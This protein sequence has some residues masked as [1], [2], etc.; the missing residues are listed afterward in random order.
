MSHKNF[1]FLFLLPFFLYSDSSHYFFSSDDPTHFHH[2]NILTGQLNCQFTDGKVDGIVSIPITRGYTSY[3]GYEK[4]RLGVDL[5]LKELRGGFLIQGGWNFFSH[6]NMLLYRSKNGVIK[7]YITEPN[8]GMLVYDQIEED[9]IDEIVLKPHP[10]S[11]PCYG[12]VSYRSQSQ[13]HRLKLNRS[14]GIATLY[15]ANGG[16]RTYFRVI[17]AIKDKE[18]VFE[19]V[20]YRLVEEILPSG[21]VIDYFYD[22]FT[23]LTRIEAKSWN[24]KILFSS[25]DFNIIQSK[26]FI[27][28][29]LMGSNGRTYSYKSDQY[30][31]RDYLSYFKTDITIEETMGYDLIDPKKGMFLTEV[32]EGF[33]LCYSV[34][35]AL[36]GEED[37]TEVYKVKNLYFSDP[38]KG[39]KTLFA[40][41]EY[42]E[43]KTIVQD[44]SSGSTQYL[45]EKDQILSIEKYDEN[46]QLL[47]IVKFIWEDGKL[48]GKVLLNSDRKGIISKTMRYDSVGNVVEE[49][50]YGDLKGIK[51][52]PFEVLKD[53]SFIDSDTYTKWFIYDENQLL[54]EE[55]EELGHRYR[56]RYLK[57]TD[58]ILEK[59]KY[60]NSKP[61]V[62]EKFFYDEHRLLIKETVEDLELQLYESIKTYKRDEKTGSIIKT[63]E[64]NSIFIENTYDKNQ[65]LIVE[66]VYDAPHQLLMKTEFFYDKK[67][68]ILKKKYSDGKQE[69]YAYD[70]FGNLVAKKEIGTPQKI[71][72]YDLH[73]HIIKT[74]TYDEKIT[75]ETIFDIRG[76]P[77]YQKNEQGAVTLRTYNCLN[78][79]IRSSSEFFGETQ[80][81][82][83]VQG[84]LE[85][86]LDPYGI[87]TRTSFTALG[88]PKSITYKNG[89]TIHHIYSLDGF[90]EKTVYEDESYSCKQMNPFCK[91]TKETWYD[92]EG[93]ELFQEV[94]DYHHFLLLHHQSKEGQKTNYQYDLHGKV[95][96]KTIDGLK[97]EYSYDSMGHLVKERYPSYTICSEYDFFGK[98]IHTFAIDSI[99]KI[100][101]EQEFTYDDDLLLIEAKTF[102]SVGVAIDRFSYD[103]YHRLIE[104]RD[105]CHAIRRIEYEK[106][107]G[108]WIKKNLDPIG[109]IEEEIFDQRGFSVSKR[110]INREGATVSKST[111]EYDL[112]G[113]QTKIICDIYDGKTFLRKK[114]IEHLYDLLGRKIGDVE[115][116]KKIKSYRY[117]RFG[118]LSS[119]CYP[120]GKEISYTFDAFKQLKRI[121]T[122]DGSVDYEITYENFQKP[123][124]F[125]SVKE[126]I[127]IERIYGEFS[128]C[129]LEKDVFDQELKYEYDDQNRLIKKIFPDQS[130]IVYAY[131][132]HLKSLKRFSPDLELRCEHQFLEYNLQGQLD[133]EHFYKHKTHTYS[134]YDLLNRKISSFNG[135]YYQNC[136]FNDLGQMESYQNSF[137]NLRAFAYDP[138]GQLVQDGEDHYAFDSLGHLKEGVISSQEELIANKDFQMRYD[139]DGN[140]VE[141]KGFNCTIEYQYDGMNRLIQID[142][143]NKK[144]NLFYD[145]LSR[146]VKIQEE[147]KIIY[148]L[149]D[150]QTDIGTRDE[151]LKLIELKIQDLEGRTLYIEKEEEIKT[152][153]VD[154]QGNIRG[155]FHLDETLDRYISMNFFGEKSNNEELLTWS[156]SSNRIIHGLIYFPERFYDPS[157]KRW[158]SKDPLGYV[159]GYN[160]YAYVLNA[161]TNRIDLFGL[162]STK[163]SLSDLKIP[164]SIELLADIGGV[165]GSIAIKGYIGECEVD[166]IIFSGRWQELSFS[167]DEKNEGVIYLENHLHELFPDEI[168][169]VGL[170]TAINGIQNSKED[171]SS[172]AQSIIQHISGEALFIGLYNP[173]EGLIGDISRSIKELRFKET[174]AVVKTRQFMEAIALHFGDNHPQLLWDHIIHSE[175]GALTRLALQTMHPE[176]K[177]KVRAQLNILAL[178]PALPIPSYMA[179][180]VKNIYS[181]SDFITGGIGR[182]FAW[183]SSYHIE[184]NNCISSWSERSFLF[185]DHAFL[186]RTYQSALEYKFKENEKQAVSF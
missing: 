13:N 56:Y 111:F 15:L 4:N 142:S 84:N 80:F 98:K 57:G 163:A 159:E 68:R 185:S 83:D 165:K 76:N 182:L 136:T 40:S 24:R 27:N 115:D 104:H 26:P 177:E 123:I 101:N 74:K 156:F 108:F 11:S 79:C 183:R 17:H 133:L 63:T 130:L 124:K 171:F 173:T 16:K 22:R 105:P 129:I 128:R 20:F 94:L 18:I 114:E 139:L 19:N 122:K 77:I 169:Q 179:R 127:G 6:T 75:S 25:L 170:I 52:G 168:G 70:Y 154:F 89:E 160:L 158:I 5:K 120:S 153:I 48:V 112:L 42:L 7:A 46:E 131:D 175:G 121:S 35:Y 157:T 21:H 141:K 92:T 58:L 149:Y 106:L 23:R 34:D 176:A 167:T 162:N 71:Y 3:G 91:V 90:I 103:S 96:E 144:T 65:R 29:Q 39:D 148:P 140:L 110:V 51:S 59:V 81:F 32:K 64:N 155:T 147:D 61:L 54:V 87:E 55:K 44:C 113:N 184:F 73:H 9:G 126:K 151:S 45:F 41:F 72:E 99:G 174:Q 82:Y 172:F 50:I 150:G 138:L 152:A 134:R 1:L 60:F 145:P 143:G 14:E 2:V 10:K 102:T 49:K 180:E 8:Q 31:G 109:Q 69:W 93:N 36:F 181:K 43:N 37:E 67:G 116:K 100:E 33:N 95:I 38:I 53:G 178:A 186:G 12:K 86:V 132:G 28:L 119:I 146:I 164:I 88:K 137:E 117:D 97:I 47:S 78:H 107:D 161:P 125:Y 85:K 118:N 166:W 30:E 66:E 62:A 135:S